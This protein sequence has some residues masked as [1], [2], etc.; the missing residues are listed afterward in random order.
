MLEAPQNSHL[1]VTGHTGG[2]EF[3]LPMLAITKEPR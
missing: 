2:E 3:F 1:T